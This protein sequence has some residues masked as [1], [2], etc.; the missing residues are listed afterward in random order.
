MSSGLGFTTSSWQVP[1]GS[2]Y[3]TSTTSYSVADASVNMPGSDLANV[4]PQ[5]GVFMLNGA[6]NGTGNQTPIP[7]PASISN[8][9][10]I[11][12]SDVDDA[13]VIYPNF[14]I[15]VFQG[16][17]YTGTA[18]AVTYNATN[19]PILTV[20]ANNWSAM[21]L[22]TPTQANYSASPNVSKSIKV[23]YQQLAVTTPVF[24]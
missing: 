4:V 9:S 15:Q 3:Y 12:A 6:P 11:A 10:A 17:G 24:S 22:F 8:L 13:Y 16:T 18:S 23:F 5:C 21:R 20:V 2:V 1:V 14:G 7:I 19:L